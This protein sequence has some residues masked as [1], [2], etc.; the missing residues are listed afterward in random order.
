MTGS[1]G[2]P[3]SIFQSILTLSRRNKSNKKKRVEDQET[4]LAATR[5]GRKIVEVGGSSLVNISYVS[6]RKEDHGMI[7]GQP[8][9]E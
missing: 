2:G 4:R 8:E 7:D 6:S 9:Y 3:Y 5:K 1:T